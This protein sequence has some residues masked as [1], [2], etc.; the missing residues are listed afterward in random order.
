MNTQFGVS[1]VLYFIK[2]LSGSHNFWYLFS[3]FFKMCLKEL[4]HALK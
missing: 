2:I 4:E 1:L 3:Q